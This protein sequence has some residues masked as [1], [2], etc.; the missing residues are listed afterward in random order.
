MGVEPKEKLRV[1]KLEEKE[2]GGGR[3]EDKQGVGQEGV[4]GRG[5]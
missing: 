4:S 5:S 2:G 3:E 1:E